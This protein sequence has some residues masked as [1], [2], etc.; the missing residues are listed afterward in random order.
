M[1]GGRKEQCTWGPQVVAAC[2]LGF[3]SCGAGGSFVEG[4]GEEEDEEERKEEEQGEARKG[5]F[6]FIFFF[7]RSGCREE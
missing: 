6:V 5:Q 3:G 4:T 1:V 2:E 7:F